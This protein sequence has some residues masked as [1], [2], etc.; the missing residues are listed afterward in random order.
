VAGHIDGELPAE[1]DQ[2]GD[3][4]GEGSNVLSRRH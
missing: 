3:E 2:L 4:V 1:S